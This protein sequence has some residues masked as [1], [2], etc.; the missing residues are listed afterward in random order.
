MN[1]EVSIANVLSDPACTAGLH[2]KGSKGPTHKE[3]SR[4]NATVRKMLSPGEAVRL[5][6][7]AKPWTLH[8]DGKFGYINDG[9]LEARW[10]NRLL[11]WSVHEDFEDGVRHGASLYDMEREGSFFGM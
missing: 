6:P 1:N 7:A 5:P 9:G 3:P 11:R 10:A 4:A 2:S 8:F